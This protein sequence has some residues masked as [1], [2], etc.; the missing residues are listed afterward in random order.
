MDEKQQ[1]ENLFRK[2]IPVSAQR[3]LMGDDLE[4]R[5]LGRH[6]PLLDS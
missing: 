4:N 1:Q 3:S 2:T 5:Q 6:Q